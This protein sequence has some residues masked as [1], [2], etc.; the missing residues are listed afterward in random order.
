VAAGYRVSLVAEERFAVGHWSRFPE[1]RIVLAGTKTDP[2]GYVERLSQVLRRGK[3]NLLMPGTERS[4]LPISEHRRLIE[5]YACL[6]LPSHEVVLRA[7]KKPLL[8]DHAA[9]VGL[10][11]P[12]SVICSKDEET[13]M[14]ARELGFPLVVKPVRSVTWTTGRIR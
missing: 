9:A 6:G 8:Q 4:L 2:E 14:I 5:P 3:Y 1:E 7:L 12:T 11:S 13:L 10:A